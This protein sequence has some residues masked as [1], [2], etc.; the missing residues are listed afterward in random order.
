MAVLIKTNMGNITVELD[1]EKAPK[2]VANFLD[3]ANKGHYNNT[4]FHR[5]IGNFMIQGGGF[6]PGMKQKPADQTVE[7]EAKN[8]LKNEN[9]TLAMARTSDPHSASAQFFINVTNNSFLDYP[10][11]DGWGYAVFGKVTEGTDV[12][13]QIKKVKTSRSGM[14]SD[15][16][17]EPVIIESV[18]VI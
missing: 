4:I 7:N 2:S 17:V 12:V 1:A 11:Q 8:G 6:E 9:Y 18:E 13:D 5:V 10:G 14:F 15:V 16:P 3:Y